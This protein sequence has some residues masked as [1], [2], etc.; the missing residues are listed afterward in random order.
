MASKAKKLPASFA[1][2][3][4]FNITDGAFCDV[5]DNGLESALPVIEHGIRATQNVSAKKAVEATEREVANIQVTQSAKT[6]GSKF[7]VS[8][9]LRGIDIR[10][11]LHSCNGDT[12]PQ[13]RSEVEDFIER[14]I[15]SNAL[16]TIADR[17]IRNCANGRWLWRNRTIA[18]TI[19]IAIENLAAFDALGVP[20][21]DFNNF[22]DDELACAGVLAKGLRGDTS[23]SIEVVATIDTGMEGCSEVY[24]SQVY[25]SNKP[26]GFA[27]PLYKL[28]NS[29]L[30]SNEKRWD[31]F[32]VVGQAALRDHKISNAIKTIDTWYE[33]YADEQRI[34]SIEPCGANLEMMKF[35][36]PEG[37]SQSAFSL[38]ADLNNVDPD[39]DDGLYCTAM[40][41]RGGV[42][43]VADKDA[44]N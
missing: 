33:G 2:Q 29:W 20:M 19:T 4:S 25:V 44:K 1:F 36:R 30:E 38:F 34:I 13:I 43:G 5:A 14:V 12:G 40:L 10:K 41:L 21:H 22:S 11:S 17:M 42:M 3:R 37:T 39:T 18:K 9:H 23:E 32:N 28:R 26:T 7:N 15:N 6:Q 31:G 16:N 35:Y 27:R 8:F 24:P